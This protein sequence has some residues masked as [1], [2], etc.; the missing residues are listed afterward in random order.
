MTSW[1]PRPVILLLAHQPLLYWIPSA[2]KTLNQVHI[3]RAA[4]IVNTNS[5]RAEMRRAIQGSLRPVP[6]R[7]P[8][9]EEEHTEGS[10]G[11]IHSAHECSSS[12]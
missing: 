2:C 11:H 9:R 1:L 7:Q 5:N 12:T 4:L 10:S 6:H 8:L 3:C